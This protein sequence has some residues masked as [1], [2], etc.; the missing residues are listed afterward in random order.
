[1][2]FIPASH[3]RTA[4]ICCPTGV[5]RSFEN[6]SDKPALMM[7]IIGGKEPGHVIWRNRSAKAWLTRTRE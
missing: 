7:V 3:D 2:L 4:A 5:M 6:I 1:L